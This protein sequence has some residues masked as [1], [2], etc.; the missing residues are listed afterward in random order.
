MTMQGVVWAGKD[1]AGDRSL[2]RKGSVISFVV[3][4][5]FVVLVSGCS[6]PL[7]TREKSVIGG[8]LLGGAAGSIL[9]AAVGSP[10]AGAAIGTALGAGTGALYGDKVQSQETLQTQQ[11][12][13]IQQNELELQRQRQEL[14]RLR[15][16]QQRRYDGDY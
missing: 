6:Q 2:C 16:Q 13:Q 11:Q 7:S 4:V 12:Q 15:Q 9:G 3:M 10:G 1:T 8:G 5:A 14:E